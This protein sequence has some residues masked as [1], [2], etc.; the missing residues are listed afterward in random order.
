MAN[1]LT[2]IK[3]R[4]HA[5]EGTGKITKSMELLSTVKSQR[6]KRE[7]ERSQSYFESL[8]YLLSDLFYFGKIE[9]NFYLKEGPKDLPSLYIVLGSDLG[10]C[11]SYNQDVIRL[12]LSTIEPKDK[13]LVIGKKIEKTL[14]EKSAAE[15]FNT[16]DIFYDSSLQN[17]EKLSE[18]LLKLFKNKK[19]RN[20]FIVGTHFIN[21]LKS[22]PVLYRIL[23]FYLERKKWENEEACPPLLDNPAEE[24]IDRL[25]ESYLVGE[26]Q[27]LFKDSELSEHTARRNAMEEANKNVDE[28]TNELTIKYNKQRQEKI[29]E[30]ITE[31]TASRMAM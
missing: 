18:T 2:Q 4:L 16:K 19:I 3:R 12:A 31:I 25:W 24:I 26:I 5:V 14:R 1:N 28:L 9:D 11:G 21:S 8:G 27:H 7:V 13:I 30:E 20:V 29:T 15:V 23:P 6:L 17:F 22:V 10:L